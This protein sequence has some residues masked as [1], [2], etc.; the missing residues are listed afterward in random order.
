[1]IRNIFLLITILSLVSCKSV[2]GQDKGNTPNILLITLD[3]MNWDSA[4]IYG[5]AIPEITPNIDELG[6]T[7]LI[8]DKGYVQAPNCSPSRSVIQTSL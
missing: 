6:K 8:F 5:N 4:G 3:D 2:S 1:M 7:G